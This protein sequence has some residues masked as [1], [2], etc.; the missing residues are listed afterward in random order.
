M[1]CANVKIPRVRNVQCSFV[2]IIH[3]ELE[4]E[5]KRRRKKNGMRELKESNP[6]LPEYESLALGYANLLY[7]LHCFM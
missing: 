6:A 1:S 2:T 7:T 5:E 3:R 4:E